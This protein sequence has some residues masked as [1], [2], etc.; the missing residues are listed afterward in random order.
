MTNTPNLLLIGADGQVGQELR[1]TLVNLGEVIPL[2]RQQIDLSQG[3]I[4]R[5]TIRDLKPQGIINAAAYTAVDQAEKEPDLAQTINGIAPQIMAEVAQTLGAWLLHI[6]TD[7]V[8]DGTQSTPYLESDSPHPLSVYGQSKLAGEMGIKGAMDNYLILRTAWVYG[9]YGKGNF[10]KTMLRLG[11]SREEIRVVADQI[12][13]PT[14]ALD[15]ATAIAALCPQLEEGKIKGIYHFTNSG[16]ASWFDFAV[17]I[18]EEAKAINIPLKIK[19][20]IPITTADYPT[21]AIRPSYSVLSG[22]KVSQTLGYYPPYWRDSLR[23]ILKLGQNH[24]L[25]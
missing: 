17:A 4:L 14:A 11:Q 5:Q 16:V 13:S 21:P 15:I 24:E 12:G 8:F 10:V 3:E 2:T 19:Q 23:K 22:Q 18:F 6:S 1:Q 20:V 7:Y 9:L 25:F